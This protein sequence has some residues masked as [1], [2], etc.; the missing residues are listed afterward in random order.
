MH[1]IDNLAPRFVGLDGNRV[2][3][4][5]AGPVRFDL[6]EFL[7]DDNDEF[8]NFTFTIAWDNGSIV[9]ADVENG[10][11]LIFMVGSAGGHARITV[12]AEDPSGA[13]TAASVE[14]DASRAGALDSG[15]LLILVAVAGVALLGFLVMR[16]RRTSRAPKAKLS[17]YEAETPEAEPEDDEKR[18]ESPK[19]LDRTEDEKMDDLL[20]QMEH[21]TDVPRLELPPVTIISREGDLA[22]SSVLLLYRDGRPMAWVA[23][24]SPDEKDVELEEELA[25]AVA[26][27]LKK[28][29]AGERIE[30]EM[31]EMGGSTFAVEGRSQLLMAARVRPGADEGA[32]RD[33]MRDALDL[34]F[35]RNAP[36]LKRWDGSKRALKGLDDALEPVFGGN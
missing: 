24:A 15:F 26:E 10:T 29:R 1:I 21:E 17:R 14:V 6:R 25:A 31:I 27:R 33:R 4:S 7:R 30:G 35:D 2:T 32:L 11:L 36:A 3:V 5:A 18:L 9:Q 28:T 23:A 16:A 34:A 13:I 19:G 8:A 22:A 12:T 20:D